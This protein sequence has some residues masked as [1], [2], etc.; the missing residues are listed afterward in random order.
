MKLILLRQSVI[1]VAGLML[2][3]WPALVNRGPFLHP[4]TSNYIR[5]ADGATVAL[6][7]RTSVWSDRL[8]RRSTVSSASA[9]WSDLHPTRTVLSGR[10][11]YYGVLLFTLLELFGKWGPVFFQSAISLSIVLIVARAALPVEVHRGRAPSILVLI[12]AVFT[13][14]PFFVSYLMPDLFTGL[15]I[16][17]LISLGLFWDQLTIG[18][19]VLLIAVASA[20]V[21]FHTTHVLIAVFGGTVLALARLTQPTSVNCRALAIAPA[22]VVLAVFAQFI[23][24]TEVQRAIGVRPISPPFL[25]ARILDDGPGLPFL[26]ATCPASGYAACKFISRLPLDSDQFLWSETRGEGVFGVASPVEKQQ[27]SE[28]D[29]RLFLAVLRAHPLEVLTV[30]VRAAAQQLVYIDYSDFNLSETQRKNEDGTL[31]AWARSWDEQTLAYQGIMPLRASRFAAVVAI[32]GAFVMLFIVARHRSFDPKG[33]VFTTIIF[34][35]VL[36]NAAICGAFSKPHQRY[37]MRVIWLVPLA[38]C[39]AAGPFCIRT[40]NEARRMQQK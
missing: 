14:L 19:R 4:D 9:G 8:A 35:M 25:S 2:F 39:L 27:L 22:L 5:A 18:G 15:L 37:Q 31:P 29:K 7:G 21:V 33:L 30:S 28:Q 26:R 36:F 38:A 23:Y 1:L 3:A 20:S 10:S 6:T 11:I 16:I 32:L 12:V 34:A 40:R 17:S 13:P 24:N